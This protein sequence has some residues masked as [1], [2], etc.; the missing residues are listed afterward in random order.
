MDN[1]NQK[2]NIC[3][4][5]KQGQKVFFKKE[6][7]KLAD[8]ISH[9]ELEEDIPVS[10]ISTEVLDKIREFCETHNYNSD[11]MT[12][13]FPFLSA[14]LKENIDEKSYQ[15]LKEY[16]IEN[17]E[18][19]IQKLSPLLEAAFYL[20][21]TKLKKI[22]NTCIQVIF[23]CGPSEEEQVQFM[24]KWGLDDEDLTEDIKQECKEQFSQ[25]IKGYQ[26]GMKSELEVLFKQYQDGKK[27]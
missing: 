10:E 16:D 3:L 15:V 7:A 6:L 9:S 2:E 4:I 11:T 24:E 25:L 8:L 20:G 18:L 13:Q 12:Y 1:L 21:F 26:Q 14:K 17:T 22:I 19:R 5:S 27:K 23:Y